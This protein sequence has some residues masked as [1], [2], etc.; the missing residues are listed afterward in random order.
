M[1]ET[2]KAAKSEIRL[3]FFE[4]L[5]GDTEGYL[6]IATTDP[7]APKATFAQTFFEWPR[8]IKR[9]EN[10]ILSVERKHNI[11]FCV[12]L[13]SKRERKKE[14]CL[15]TDMLWSDLDSVNPDAIQDYPPPIIL[16]SS[17]GRWQALWRMTTKLSPFQAEDYS[18]RLAY[19]LGADK[20]GW[21]LGQLLRVPLTINWK[22][23]TP[24]Q[25]ELQ[26]M[27]EI[28][29][30]P[31][32]FEILEVDVGLNPTSIEENMPQ[33][34]EIL[35][36]EQIIYKYGPLLEKTAF[37]ALFTQDPEDK[38][39]SQVLWRLLHVC[40]KVGMSIEETFAVALDAKCNKYARDGRPL[41][42]L[43]RDVLKA[44]AEYQDIGG[45]AANLIDMPHLVDEDDSRITTTFVDTYRE[46]ATVATDAVSDFHDLSILT[47]L[48]A[49]VSSSVKLPTSGK[50]I[51]PNIWG[52]IIGESTITRKTTAMSLAMEF[53][54]TLD[55]D[56]IVA[57]DGSAEGLLGSLSQRP[58]RASMFY[59]DEISGLF[60]SMNKKDYLAGLKETFTKLYD[61]PPIERRVLRKETIIIESPAFVI[62]CGGV[63]DGINSATNQ[64]FVTSGFLPRFIVVSGDATPDYRRPLG[65]P[66]TDTD[67]KKIEI[68][69]ALADIY[70]VYATDV[71][72]HIGG[73]AVLMPPRYNARMTPDAW[74]L[75]AEFDG[76][77][78]RAGHESLVRGIALPTMERLGRSLLKVA[79]ILAAIRQ[80]P[81]EQGDVLV[82]EYDL[83]NA[84]TY[85][86]K[87][88]HHSIDLVLNVGKGSNERHLE[89]IVAFIA[90]KPGVLKS[91]IMNTQKLSAQEAA[92][93]LQTLE[94]RGLIR[95]ERRGR[96][97]AY[98][99][100]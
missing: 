39:W 12:N 8:E 87:W 50:P 4:T 7:R 75:N 91:T 29:A 61:V 67:T 34:D 63:P 66:N 10:F 97:F 99:I 32:I 52:I 23:N 86:Q 41:E 14:N 16:R 55:P 73:Q 59:R 20:S 84:A 40:L 89:R 93:I 100:T 28:A 9:M 38:T 88:G 37:L 45:S 74:K 76:A 13:L 72:Q 70:E 60:D 51:T 96:G 19:H 31:A 35:E 65:P 3:K 92:G 47:V 78:L 5:F 44:G 68:L 64:S 48:S 82:E 71:K 26:R 54:H 77:F 25:V 53:L 33:I 15:P 95:A 94:E 24:V 46:W 79:I 49:I 1:S 81:D 27:S 30:E 36:S 2:T 85:I 80:K 62:L 57:T 18:R 98:W 90:N 58:N 6:C 21:D 43:W 56:L 22:Y 11:Y 69:N 83:L 42:H 17:P